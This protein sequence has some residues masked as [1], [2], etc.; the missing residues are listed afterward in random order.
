MFLVV[1]IL[2]ATLTYQAI[3][4]PPGGVWQDNGVCI[5]TEA[6]SSYLQIPPFNKTV[7]SSKYPKIIYLSKSNT[8]S[9]CEHKTGIAIALEDRLF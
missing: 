6:G 1:A 8:T 5:T 3:L 2:L 4:T 7:G 9:A